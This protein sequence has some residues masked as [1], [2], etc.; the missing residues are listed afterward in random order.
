MAQGN[1]MHEELSVER[2]R[3]RMLK[4]AGRIWGAASEEIESTFDPIV[5]MLIEACSVE[6]NKINTEIR[7]S[8]T[9]VLSQLARILSP[10]AMTGPKPSHAIAH[11]RSAEAESIIDKDVQFYT[12]KKISVPDGIQKEVNKEIF[13]SPSGLFKIFDGDVKY[14]ACNNLLHEYKSPVSRQLISEGQ[15]IG[16]LE[17]NTVWLALEL[18]PRI[19]SLD[20]LCFFFD[21]K[22]DPDESSYLQLLPFMRINLQEHQLQSQPGLNHVRKSNEPNN[23]ILTDQFDLS[24]NIETQVNKIYQP[25]FFTL[26]NSPVKGESL[27]QLK[28][29]FPPEFKDVFSQQLLDKLTGT[30]L[31]LKIQFTTAMP[32]SAISDCYIAINSFPVVNRKLNKL[33]YRLQNNLNIVPLPS[34]DLFLDLYGVQTT[35]GKS[36]IA[37]PLSSGFKNEA[38]HFTLRNGGI[39]RFDSRQSTELLNY[40]LDLLRDESAAFSSLGNDFINGYIRQINQALAMIE[41]RIDQKGQKKKPTSFILI[42]PHQQDDNIFV[43]YWTTNGLTGNQVK[44]GTRLMN[45]TSG[46]TKSETLILLTSSYGGRESLNE[47]EKIS[48][49]KKSLL[50]HDRI[51]TEEDIRTTCLYELGNLATDISIRKNWEI[52]EHRAQGLRRIIEVC[53]RKNKTSLLSEKEWAQVCEE[54]RVKLEHKSAFALPVKV[55]TES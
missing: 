39:E 51:V 47:N 53:I 17:Q 8:Q 18:N 43:R 35:D 37:N 15:S 6:L 30:Y 4:N 23:T 40:I 45:Y 28:Q 29:T 55:I 2:I 21:W 11:A 14:F 9:R 52:I 26:R 49:Y 25:H 38:G 41:N 5:T 33:T 32:V 10:E 31:W 19:Q 13:F 1:D 34:E 44:S 27:Q 20:D 7:S 22:N 12:N 50:S 54:L 3:S 24:F 16:T 46:E 42:R 48:A 36:F